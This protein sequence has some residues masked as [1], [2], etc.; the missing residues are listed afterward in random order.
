MIEYNLDS[1][2]VH[3]ELKILLPE[4]KYLDKAVAHLIK[5]GLLD[6]SVEHI[7]ADN[8]K[9]NYLL[10]IDSSWVHNLKDVVDVLNKV[11]KKKWNY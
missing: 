9:H 3:F 4:K 10:S 11:E 2:C 1:N 8:G 7:H 6:F 5:Q